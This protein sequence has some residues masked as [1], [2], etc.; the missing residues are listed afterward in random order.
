MA[1]RKFKNGEFVRIV[2]PKNGKPHPYDGF[3]GV[4]TDE[5]TSLRSVQV[6]LRF[7]NRPVARQDE[8]VEYS[9]VELIRLLPGAE[10][11]IRTTA[12]KIVA[13]YGKKQFVDGKPLADYT[14]LINKYSN[15][16]KEEL[17]YADDRI[18][19]KGDTIHA[20]KM[21]EADKLNVR[22]GDKILP[23]GGLATVSIKL[24]NKIP[25]HDIYISPFAGKDA[26][27]R[28]IKP[29]RNKAILNDINPLVYQWWQE[30]YLP[31]NKRDFERFKKREITLMNRDFRELINYDFLNKYC[32]NFDDVFYL[33]DPPFL[34]S[35]RP[36]YDNNKYDYE[37]TGADHMA[38]L[39]MCKT[40]TQRRDVKMMIITYPS[41][42]YEKELSD[43]SRMELSYPVK[44]RTQK[45]AILHVYMNYDNPLPL[46]DV[47]FVGG[48]WDERRALKRK[49]QRHVKKFEALPPEERAAL[50][51][52]LNEKFNEVA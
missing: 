3:V 13:V 10:V 29:A 28:K 42:L 18:W 30:Q 8:H 31:N 4:I 43:W 11:S 47:R 26:V 49:I 50:L 6:Q 9:Q 51:T 32:S 44:S 52:V 23:L 41:Q 2:T 7:S 17:E 1:K 48:N 34:P 12:H 20:V 39:T 25:Q 38:L 14:P 33:I 22:S 15:L 46:H 21:A 19:I 16:S 37:L 45:V 24:I 5:F 35:T 36:G 27:F 40:L